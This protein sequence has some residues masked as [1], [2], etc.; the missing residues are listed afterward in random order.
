V[1][2]AFVQSPGPSEALAQLLMA[3]E[4][5][6]A[7]NPSSPRVGKQMRGPPRPVASP[8]GRFS[9]HTN[10][11]ACARASEPEMVVF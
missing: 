6:N 2:N 11:P 3:K 7:F 1:Q 8:Q 5:V 10:F 9:L 4:P